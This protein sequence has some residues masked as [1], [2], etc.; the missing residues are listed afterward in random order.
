MRPQIILSR[1][2]R[3]L[4]N[5]ALFWAFCFA[6]LFPLAVNH[7]PV[8]FSDTG[9]YIA[10]FRGLNSIHNPIDRPIFYSALVYAAGFFGKSLYGTVFVQALCYSYVFR[11]A[12]GTI[13]DREGSQA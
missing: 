11:R 4:R 5:V 7:Y 8:V 2:P 6:L 13:F 9:E 12:L 3:G 10:S 1:I